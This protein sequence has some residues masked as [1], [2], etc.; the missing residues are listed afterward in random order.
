VTI[1][2]RYRRKDARV[3][4]VELSLQPIPVNGDRIVAIAR[5]ITGRKHAEL[6]REL[7]YREALEAVRARDEFLQVA[8][9]E[10][11]TPLTSLGLQ[12]DLLLRRRGAAG[13]TISADRLDPR[14]AVIARQVD[15]LSELI[16]RLM[17]VTRIASGH[18][19]LELD[20]VDLA[21]LTAEVVARLSEDAKRAQSTISVSGPP[22]VGHWD[23]LRLEQVVTNLLT[24]ALKFGAGQPIELSV[25]AGGRGARLTVCDHGI[26]IG[27]ED[28]ARIFERFERAVS[29]RSFAGMGLGL[30]IVRQIVQAHGGTIQ[31]ESQL[32]AG[33][34]FTVDIPLEPPASTAPLDNDR[35]EATEADATAGL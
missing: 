7:L 32:G 18:L 33:S 12:V 16:T 31:L 10:L 8:S 1:E 19:R 34:A 29:N 25:T 14:L 11:R 20:E 15:R 3:V 27:A 9:H 24:N 22:L 23:R 13:T 5:D 35:D 28:I 17:D 26:G 21:T 4:P 30:Y 6:E 2:T